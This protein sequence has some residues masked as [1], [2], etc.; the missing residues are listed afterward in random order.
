MEDT[1]K[2]DSQTN[3]SNN[4]RHNSLSITAEFGR[5]IDTF[6][7]K[8][9]PD[10]TLRNSARYSFGTETRSK[11]VRTIQNARVL[12]G[13]VG[14]GPKYM[15]KENTKFDRPA[16]FSFGHEERSNTSMEMKYAYYE[17]RESPDIDNSS[18]SLMHKSPVSPIMGTE[19]R[20]GVPPLVTSPGP[21]YMSKTATSFRREPCA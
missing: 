16:K 21:I 13:R 11:P 8:S 12:V 14:P 15:V 19:R 2:V 4:R 6:A 5:P 7:K 3:F 1:T 17:G 18:T 10:S 9:I 20:E